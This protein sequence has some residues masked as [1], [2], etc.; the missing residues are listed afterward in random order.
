MDMC[1]LL[2]LFTFSPY[3]SVWYSLWSPS[4]IPSRLCLFTFSPYFSVWYSLWSPS[5]IP[6][7]YNTNKASQ[8]SL[9]ACLSPERHLPA[10]TNL[11]RWLGPPL[12]CQLVSKRHQDQHVRMKQ[13][14]ISIFIVC[15]C[16]SAFICHSC[17][18]DYPTIADILSH[19]LF[20]DQFD[21]IAKPLVPFDKT[22]IE[23]AFKG[24]SGNFY[25]S[26]CGVLELQK[27]SY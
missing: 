20:F 23:A 10:T 7:R 2:C 24:S 5:A 6:S 21:G 25:V 22:L 26:Y 9:Q 8:S 12:L 14:I 4:A 11:V 17:W 27:W 16:S 18:I 3:F 15:T 19:P 1:Q 13:G